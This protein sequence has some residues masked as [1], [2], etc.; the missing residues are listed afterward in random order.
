MLRPMKG[1]RAAIRTCPLCGIAMQGTK[2]KESLP[3]FDTFKCQT[4]GTTIR[5]IKTNNGASTRISPSGGH[6]KPGQI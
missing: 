6:R 3:H 4:C 1:P 2:S 5:E